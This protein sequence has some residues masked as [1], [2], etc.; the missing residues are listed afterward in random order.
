MRNIFVLKLCKMIKRGELT[1]SENQLLYIEQLDL[2]KNYYKI[3][4]DEIY[5]FNLG[6]SQLEVRFVVFIRLLINYIHSLNF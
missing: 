4:Y 1:V 2:N 5:F 3:P 6:D